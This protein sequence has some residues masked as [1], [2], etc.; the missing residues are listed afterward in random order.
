MRKAATAK[1][2][3]AKA[4]GAKVPSTLGEL[5]W[6]KYNLPKSD[7]QIP[8]REGT[9]PTGGIRLT[10]ADYL[11]DGKAID[12][13]T[14]FRNVFGDFKWKIASQAPYVEVALVPFEITIKGKF[15][16]KF[17]LEI[18]HK[19]SGEAGQGNYT[20]SISWGEA[21]EEIREAYLVGANL[22]LY[23]PSKKGEP[24]QIVFT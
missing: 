23:R 24:F 8:A 17:N 20:T 18:R 1:A 9:N 16:G 11:V 2:Q 19:P 15:I 3:P 5:V 6:A 7:V 13:T 22:E 12:Q 14:Y 10:Q 4:A 21:G